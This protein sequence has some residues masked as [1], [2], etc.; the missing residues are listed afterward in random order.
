[1]MNVERRIDEPRIS[2]VTRSGAVT[3]SDK[4]YEKKEYETTWIR[5]TT[6][7]YLVFYI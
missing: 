5:K 4:E 2:M 3:R 1:M 6:K 7:K